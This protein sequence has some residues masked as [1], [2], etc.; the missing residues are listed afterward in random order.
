MLLRMSCPVCG[1]VYKNTQMYR[2]TIES[3]DGEV[4]KMGYICEKC[5]QRNFKDIIE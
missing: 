3:L 4:R 2:I 5:Y 1:K